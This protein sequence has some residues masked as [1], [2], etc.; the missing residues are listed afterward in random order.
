M[1]SDVLRRLM[2]ERNL[3]INDLSDKTDLPV[4]TIKNILYGKVID[5]RASTV[6]VLARVL[7]VTPDEILGYTSNDEEQL[8]YNY[9]KCGHHG[10]QLVEFMADKHALASVK[11]E[12][13]E[14]VRIAYYEPVSSLEDGIVEATSNVK[15]I[16]AEN[17]KAF[18]GY[19]IATNNFI[20]YYFYNGDIILLEK[21]APQYGEKAVFSDG[22][23]SYFRIFEE[24]DKQCFRFK[25]KAMNDK[26]E[27]L[28]INDFKDR[29]IC[30]GTCIDVVRG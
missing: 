27:D 9:R 20:N 26:G 14:K 28:Y 11:A 13:N 4:E 1:I 29:F 12:E 10:K 16:D 18:V 19:K 21:R 6:I 23:I 25:L 22:H 15:Y 8:L 7:K 17:T 24:S 30:V 5:P 2:D 3:T